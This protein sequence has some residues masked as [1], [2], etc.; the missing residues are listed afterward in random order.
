MAARLEELGGPPTPEELL[1]YR[2]GR[3]S[4]EERERMEARIAA[5]PDAARALI[6]LEAFPDIEPAPGVPEL[7][8]EDLAAGWQAFRQRLP[9][10]AAPRTETPVVPLASPG[11]ATRPAVSRP[12]SPAGPARRRWAPALRLAA[13]IL[14]GIVVGWG[15]GR[16]GWKDRNVQ[17]ASR[18]AINPLVIELSPDGAGLRSAP[19]VIELPADSEVL[20][21]TLGSDG[22]E[23]R[24]F[25]AYEAEGFDESGRKVWKRE[26]LRP[27][28]VGT[29]GLTLPRGA[30]QPGRY[31]I[32]LYGRDRGERQL[33]ATYPLRLLEAAPAP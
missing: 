29:F 16:T 9:D 11:P 15:A 24:E 12:S 31:R 2:D 26:G 10:R 25:P 19:E 32:D 5:D 21:L 7:S 17:V 18:P 6:D 3:L 23:G 4:P 1:A 8:D 27:T 20:V 30:M 33:L 14:F 13:G 28:D 22:R